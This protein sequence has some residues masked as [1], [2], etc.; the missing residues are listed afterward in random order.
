MSDINKM[1]LHRLVQTEYG[2]EDEVLLVEDRHFFSHP[3]YN[4]EWIEQHGN[5]FVGRPH[6]NEVRVK[7]LSGNEILTLPAKFQ[8]PIKLQKKTI[9][10][11]DLETVTFVSLEP[12][13]PMLEKAR[14]VPILVRIAYDEF[15]MF[16]DKDIKFCQEGYAEINLSD[17]GALGELN[18]PLTL[19]TLLSLINGHCRMHHFSRQLREVNQD[20]WFAMDRV[21]KHYS[22]RSECIIDTVADVCNIFGLS[23]QLV[24]NGVRVPTDLAQIHFNSAFDS[25]SDEKS[26]T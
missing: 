19:L 6:P 11:I 5:F 12:T 26:E 14:S 17:F 25:S 2:I 20:H 24:F 22:F 23:P 16:Y 4:V 7:S 13:H 21:K 18:E 15:Y 9:D 10:L 3:L 8:D 1:I